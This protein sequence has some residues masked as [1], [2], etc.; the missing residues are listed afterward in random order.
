MGPTLLWQLPEPL[1]LAYG[2]LKKIV[3]PTFLVVE[4]PKCFPQNPQR[5]IYKEKWQIDE[6][7][8]TVKIVSEKWR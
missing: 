5:T 4:N 6:Q 7:R 8:S 1:E 2:W 3:M